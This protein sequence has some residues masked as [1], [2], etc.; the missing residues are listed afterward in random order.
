MKMTPRIFSLMASIP[1]KTLLQNL[2]CS[3]MV[4]LFAA[5]PALPFDRAPLATYLQM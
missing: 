5:W 1:L 2:V 4:S 3:F